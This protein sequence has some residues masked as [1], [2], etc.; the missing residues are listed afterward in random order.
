MDKRLYYEF[1]EMLGDK[2]NRRGF[3]VNGQIP[4]LSAPQA[5]AYAMQEFPE[6]APKDHP[7]EYNPVRC[8]ELAAPLYTELV[9]LEQFINTMREE[10]YGN[11]A[12]L[13]EERDKIATKDLL[14]QVQRELAQ[15]K[16]L[17]AG[18]RA[19][20][21]SDAWQY[22]HGRKYE[23]WRCTQLKGE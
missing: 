18:G 1:M 5:V 17:S 14:G 19:N 8:R 11:A 13:A 6:L 21:L 16:V 4:F 10:A 9:M 12:Y 20:G 7:I 2:Q 22:I 3:V 15:E 23:L